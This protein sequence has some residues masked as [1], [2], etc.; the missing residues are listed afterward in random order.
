MSSEHYCMKTFY[1]AVQ[2]WHIKPQ[3]TTIPTNSL[4]IPSKMTQKISSYKFYS[5]NFHLTTRIGVAKEDTLVRLPNNISTLTASTTSS[6]TVSQMDY[7]LVIIKIDIV[8][9]NWFK[10][11][12]NCRI[13]GQWFINEKP[14]PVSVV[15][16]AVM[17]SFFIINL[18]TEKKLL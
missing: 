17:I 12:K 5:T 6:S 4:T 9:G 18:Q 1:F 13:Q 8:V 7:V 3:T 16:L 10:S 15:K 11:R 14:F 2:P